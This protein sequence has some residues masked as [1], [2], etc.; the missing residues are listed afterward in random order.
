[1]SGSIQSQ[2]GLSCS[3][4]WAPLRTAPWRSTLDA[5]MIWMETSS[6][7][8]PGRRKTKCHPNSLRRENLKMALHGIIT[9]SNNSILYMPCLQISQN[10]AP[11]IQN[12]KSTAGRG[13]KFPSHCTKGNLRPRHWLNWSQV[14]LKAEGSPPGLDSTMDQTIT[15]SNEIGSFH[16]KQRLE[17]SWI[18]SV[19]NKELWKVFGGMH[20]N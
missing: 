14:I 3:L 5:G 7:V 18:I 16:T 19:L 4:R 17:V 8:L 13:K 10:E 9:I 1:M 12:L 20:D 11:L 15:D 6:C 2:P